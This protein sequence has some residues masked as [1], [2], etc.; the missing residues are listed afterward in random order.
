MTAMPPRS[1][2]NFGIM[3][4]GTSVNSIPVQARAKVDLRSESDTKLDEMANLLHSCVERALE[5][6]NERSTQGRVQVR[7]RDIG[8][9]PGGVLAEDA[10]LLS[11]TEVIRRILSMDVACCRTVSH[12]KCPDVLSCFTIL[13]SLSPSDSS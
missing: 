3:E 13:P 5:V 4:G 7:I 10:S 1:S 12:A 8:A 9:R 11:A 6:E 2:F